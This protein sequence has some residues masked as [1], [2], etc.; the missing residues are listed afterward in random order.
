MLDCEYLV[1]VQVAARLLRL[2]FLIPLGAWRFVCCDSCV[3]S[4]RGLSDGLIA[5]PERS[6]RVWCAWVWSWSLDN[7]EA[8]VH[9]GAPASLKRKLPPRKAL[10]ST[11]RCYPL[12]KTPTKLQEY[13]F[14]AIWDCLFNL[15]AVTLHVGGRSSICQPR[16]RYV[17]LKGT[18][19]SWP[20]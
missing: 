1:L 12:V 5:C 16:T 19:L 13:L 20:K 17:R 14:S 9:K 7:E 11:A 10:S 8:L 15:F 2:W 4:G 18:R 6:Y 3:L